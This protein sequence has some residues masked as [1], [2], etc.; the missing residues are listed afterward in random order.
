MYLSLKKAWRGGRTDTGVSMLGAKEGVSAREGWVGTEGTI[1]ICKKK[2][3]MSQGEK[4]RDG[5]LGWER[6]SQ[7]VR[8]SSTTCTISP[9]WSD[10]RAGNSHRSSSDSYC[11][12]SQ[13]QYMNLFQ[14]M[15]Y[16]G[17]PT[18]YLFFYRP[19]R[20][21]ENFPFHAGCRCVTVNGERSSPTAENT[22]NLTRGRLSWAF[23]GHIK[24]KQT[25]E[26][27]DVDR[28][29][30]TWVRSQVLK[31]AWDYDFTAPNQKEF[32]LQ[33]YEKR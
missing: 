14:V 9:R 1:W 22:R 28:K 27:D 25:H 26:A 2:K 16:A 10:L 3:K 21:K 12:A 30:N 17:K 32:L 11:T 24:Q 29:S 6:C 13:N 19:T 15:M 33:E 31:C 5:L 4:H 7:D 8:L 20:G 18:G 23:P